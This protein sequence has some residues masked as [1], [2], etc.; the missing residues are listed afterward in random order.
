MS[1]KR[2][3]PARLD[4]SIVIVSWNVRQLLRDCLRSLHESIDGLIFEIIRHQAEQ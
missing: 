1:Q 2:K 3:E 4:L